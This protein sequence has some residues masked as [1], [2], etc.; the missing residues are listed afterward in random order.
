MKILYTTTFVILSLMLM[1]NRMGRGNQT[2]VGATMA[3]GETGQFCGQQGC[4]ATNTFSPE[5]NIEVLDADGNT[6][7]EYVPGSTYNVTYEAVA[8]QSVAAGYGFMMISLDGD[9]NPIET[10]ADLPDLTRSI[11]LG[12]RM[13]VEHTNRIAAG[14]KLNFTWSAP[15]DATTDITFYAS[16][17]VVNGNNNASG[18]SGLATTFVLPISTDSSNA[19][20]KSENNISVYPNPSVDF[21]SID[22]LKDQYARYSIYNQSGLL[23]LEGM[24]DSNIEVAGLQSGLYFVSVGNS[25]VLK[26]FKL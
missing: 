2:G 6:V 26:F 22:N 4:H 15:S 13:Y 16:S 1:S 7:S 11:D 9:N 12:G 19:D 23:V 21:I 17:A 20:L 18:D 14:T 10:W 8:T 24:Y 5:I 25:K 3:P